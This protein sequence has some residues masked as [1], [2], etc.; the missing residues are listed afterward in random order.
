MIS[1]CIMSRSLALNYLSTFWTLLPT[2]HIPFFLSIQ[3]VPETTLN[4]AE[5]Q[6][7][8]MK[9]SFL[10]WTFVWLCLLLVYF[11][12]ADADAYATRNYYPYAGLSSDACFPSY[13][14]VSAATGEFNSAT[15]CTV[16][17]NNYKVM[18]SSSD[19]RWQ[20]SPRNIFNA[21]VNGYVGRWQEGSY[22][23]CSTVCSWLYSSTNSNGITFNGEWVMIKIPAPMVLTSITIT[24]GN[25]VTYQLYGNTGTATWTALATTPTGNPVTSIAF[26]T[27]ST[28][29]S[30][31]AL[32]VSQISLG[33]TTLKMSSMTL[34][35]NTCPAGKWENSGSGGSCTP[36]DAGTYWGTE[37]SYVAT[38]PCVNCANGKYSAAGASVCTDCPAGKYAAANAAG[39]AGCTACGGGTF[40]TITGATASGDCTGQCVAGKFT[41]GGTSSCAD[42]AAGTYSAA[43]AASC[44]ACG[45]TDTSVAGSSSCRATADCPAGYKKSGQ[46]CLPCAAGTITAAV[47]A[48]G[49][50]T[51][52]ADGKYAPA[53]S[54][55]CYDCP[56]GTWGAGQICTCTRCLEGTYSST[57]GATQITDCVACSAGYYSLGTGSS[58][59]TNCLACSP[60]TYSAST[61]GVSVCSNC[62]AGKYSLWG[63]TVCTDCPAGKYSASTAASVCLDC[64]A[65][66][67]C[68]AGATTCVTCSP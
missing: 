9:S 36:C 53:V 10:A 57:T 19:G 62:A 7:E 4:L 16:S 52:C 18:F 31:F 21:N 42:C 12:R 29:Y 15:G 32:V 38:T 34:N 65:G 23:V 68:A 6:R 28:Y 14:T 5:T 47:N 26:S 58:S 67:T 51:N 61:T 44:T 24:G 46:Q 3:S 50:C 22:S 1:T 63:A 17:S 37:G 25:V 13:T 64:S 30:S 56:A 20:Y 27:S 40:T 59:S 33:T 39:L 60:G 54:S 55:A 8:K 43:A 48:A 11:P 2:S 49:S 41:A 35:G 45:S 66:T